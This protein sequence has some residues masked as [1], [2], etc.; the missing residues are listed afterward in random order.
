M[1][2][3]GVDF[4]YN[5]AGQI[6]TITRYAD[7]D[8]DT[9][10][11]GTLT[12][13]VSTFSYSDDLGWLTGLVHELNDAAQTEISYGY[14]YQDD[15]RIDTIDSSED[16]LYDYDY[17][18]TGQLTDV[19]LDST[20]VEGYDYDAN[21]N[22]TSANGDTYTTTAFNRL[23]TIDDGTNVTAYGYDY[24]GNLTLT[25]IDANE[26]STLDSGDTDIVEYAWDHRNRLVGV[27][28]YDTFADYG[29]TSSQ[30]VDYVYDY[31]NR[32][33]AR[34]IDED[35]SGATY[36]DET[37][38]YVYDGGEPGTAEQ[39]DQDADVGQ[40]VLQ[41]D[42]NGAPTHRYLWGPAVDQIL[43]DEVVDDGTAD[44]VNWT[45]TDHQ[46]TVRDLVEYN[47]GTN[48]ASVINHITYDSY[49]NALNAVDC[50]FAF[51]GRLSDSA[52]GLQNNLNRW[53]D[54]EVGRWLSEDPIG[55]EG[56]DANLYRYVANDPG[57][58]VDPSGLE[59]SNP[60]IPIGSIPIPNLGTAF[61]NSD[62]SATLDGIPGRVEFEGDTP[63]FIP[64][65]PNM[66]FPTEPS[67]LELM[68]D[69]VLTLLG[70]K[71]AKTGG[72]LLF[73][74]GDDAAKGLDKVADSAKVADKAA[75]A[76]KTADKAADA[77]KKATKTTDE[78]F[79]QRRKIERAEELWELNQKR[80][81]YLDMAEDAMSK[82]REALKNGDVK[83]A[84]EW[85]AKAKELLELAAEPK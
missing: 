59:G 56:G 65:D 48:T 11:A 62:G 70:M 81:R 19:T 47:P 53:Y 64:D 58:G 15:G 13:A 33:V 63:K 39:P 46:N 42:E 36:S 40:I 23:E 41:L 10:T 2:A 57:N 77:A 66:S 3:K 37:E 75:D 51:T 26:N 84:S 54:P 12:V 55:F 74:W 49:G 69:G 35:G 68:V 73:R 67:T 18:E 14:T 5:D 28:N 4:T 29:T 32:L 1:A 34:T 72:S 43:A 20:P 83:K 85:R 25:F 30:E 16:G 24:E 52:T 21:G 60:P 45:L 76:A 61:V 17:D 79:E 38:Y 50:L 44:D 22:R 6:A 78:W 9:D 31:L 80:G 27:T 7:A 71:A 8:G 82:A